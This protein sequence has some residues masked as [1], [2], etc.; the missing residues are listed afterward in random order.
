MSAA[1]FTWIDFASDW[2]AKILDGGIDAPFTPRQT[3]AL[4]EVLKQSF[5]LFAKG[6]GDI[7]GGRLAEMKAQVQEITD[8]QRMRHVNDQRE[9]TTARR[10][11]PSSRTIGRRFRRKRLRDKFHAAKFNE[12]DTLEQCDHGVFREA[13]TCTTPMCLDQLDG[14]CKE[15]AVV[16]QTFDM[17]SEDPHDEVINV[18]MDDPFVLP[19]GRWQSPSTTRAFG[20]G[21]CSAPMAEAQCGTIARQTWPTRRRQRAASTVLATANDH[22][23]DFTRNALPVQNDVWSEPCPFLTFGSDEETFNLAACSTLQATSLTWL[24]LRVRGL[25]QFQIL[26]IPYPWLPRPPPPGLEQLIRSRAVT[27]YRREY[28]HSSF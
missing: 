5:E 10:E 16:C 26:Q 20:S 1:Q 15:D 11:V 9:A 28:Q 17:G 3:A 6:V 13:A 18:G 12:L 2:L 14:S 19:D 24:S 21:F 23:H 4:Q 25:S 7:F 8:C 27:P 22:K